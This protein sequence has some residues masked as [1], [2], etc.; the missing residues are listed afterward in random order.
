MGIDKLQ[1]E[2]EE[3]NF[4]TSLKD[5]EKI[6]FLHDAQSIGLDLSIEKF[7]SRIIETKEDKIK[8]QPFNELFQ[9]T[10]HDEIISSNKKIIIT[11]MN[12]YLHLNSDSLSLIRQFVFKLFDDGHILFRHKNAK[13]IPGV[14]RLRFYRCYEI[15]GS[16]NPF[17]P[18]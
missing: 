15:I 10:L 2:Q 6:E 3:Y 5:K 4:F 1:I 13:K 14:D 18:N 9:D 17:C 11:T 16:G 12:N 7:V 8:K